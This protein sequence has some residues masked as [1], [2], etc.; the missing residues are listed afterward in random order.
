MAIL[1]SWLLSRR[2]HLT[3]GIS[4]LVVA[5][6]GL[7][8]WGFT[9][10]LIDNLGPIASQAL[11]SHIT[12]ALMTLFLFAAVALATPMDWLS[13]IIPIMSAI[14]IIDSSFMVYRGLMGGYFQAWWVFLN[15]SLDASFLVVMYPLLLSHL[16]DKKAKTQMWI[17]LFF[18]VLALLAIVISKSNTGALGLIVVLMAY[19]LAWNGRAAPIVAL[20]SFP[21]IL[22]AKWYMGAKFL[23]SSAREPMWDLMF[24]WWFEHANHFLGTGPGTFWIYGPAVQVIANG[25]VPDPNFQ[26]FSWMHNDWLQ[27]LF[28]NGSV[29]LATI[30]A[31]YIYMLKRAWEIPCLFAMVVGYGFI[32]LAQYPL[33]LFFFQLLGVG[34]LHAC[35]SKEGRTFSLK[36]EIK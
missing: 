12:S 8:N 18:A 29:G 14:A 22:L 36:M 27:I 30:V 34:L 5:L 32:A 16:I 10:L 1:I 7:F 2:F 24:K 35:F 23:T 4:F 25:K 15:S 31:L 17:R 19:A 20:C 21:M 3:V 9:E 6:Y 13:L 33:H 28:E 26:V 11:I